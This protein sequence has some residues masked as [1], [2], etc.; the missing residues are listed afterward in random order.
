M[1]KFTFRLLE[2]LLKHLG[3]NLYFILE[4]CLTRS[5]VF[6]LLSAKDGCLH[7]MSVATLTAHEQGAHWSL[8]WSATGLYIN[9][10][11]PSQLRKNI[12]TTTTPTGMFTLYCS[13]ADTKS[14]AVYIVWRPMNSDGTELEQVVHIHPTFVPEL[15]GRAPWWTKSQSSLQDMS[16]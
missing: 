3:S 10:C 1:T 2:L 8:P 13:P 16:V 7:L 9:I 14:Y 4:K 12:S 11:T 5:T 6:L 15:V